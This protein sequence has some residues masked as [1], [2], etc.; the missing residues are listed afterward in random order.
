MISF[1]TSAED[2]MPHESTRG[3]TC[4]PKNLM[5][6]QHNILAKI[7]EEDVLALR[8]LFYMMNWIKAI[9]SLGVAKAGRQLG[10]NAP[11]LS[12]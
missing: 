10:D 7:T 9:V 11:Y 8:V 6:L 2:S 12:C 3:I 5:C 4:P 1:A